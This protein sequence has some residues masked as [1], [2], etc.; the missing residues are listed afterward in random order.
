MFDY[1]RVDHTISRCVYL[2]LRPSPRCLSPWYHSLNVLGSADA[3]TQTCA[4]LR[5]R[6]AAE[7]PCPVMGN[8]MIALGEGI[9]DT[10]A[11]VND[12]GM[13]FSIIIIITIMM[14]IVLLFFSLSLLWLVHDHEWM[15]IHA[16][17]RS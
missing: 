14:I 11:V 8:L 4:A 6:G 5:S 15:F 12:I 13:L 2:H 9:Y 10:L 16:N 7:V 17:H 3:D 1:Q